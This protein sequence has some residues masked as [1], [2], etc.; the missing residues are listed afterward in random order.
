L[1]FGLRKPWLEILLHLWIHRELQDGLGTAGIVRYRYQ[2]PHQILQRLL[3]FWILVFDVFV[4]IVFDV[5]EII[6]II[7]LAELLRRLGCPSLLFV[8]DAASRIFVLAHRISLLF[9]GSVC[10]AIFLYTKK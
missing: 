2:T 1:E 7:M 10:Q 4:L 3:C 9:H 5:F 8:V 6:I